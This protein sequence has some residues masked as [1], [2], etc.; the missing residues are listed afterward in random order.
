MLGIELTNST[1]YSSNRIHILNVFCPDMT[2]E[3]CETT[4]RKI[5]V[6]LN[7]ILSTESQH[8]E[9][10]RAQNTYLSLA[11]QNTYARSGVSSTRYFFFSFCRRL[12]FSL[13]FWLVL[14]SLESGDFVWL[15]FSFR[16]NELKFKRNW[17]TTSFAELVLCSHTHRRVSCIRFRFGS[18]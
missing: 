16:Q 7:H 10:S 6:F 11:I 15:P 12:S 4:T 17:W 5:V 1:I 18:N 14:F 13:A 3:C 2:F 9:Q 8:R